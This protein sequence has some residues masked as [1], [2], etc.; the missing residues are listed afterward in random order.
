MPVQLG[1]DT[2]GCFARWGKSGAKYHYTCGNENQ[3]NEAKQKA[4]KQGAAIGY[5]NNK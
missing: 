2:K 4:Y 5:T 1:K 3:R